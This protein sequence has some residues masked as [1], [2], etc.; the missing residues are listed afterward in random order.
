MFKHRYSEV[1]RIPSNSNGIQAL[2]GYYN[3]QRFLARALRKLGVSLPILD[4]FQDE[5]INF[6]TVAIRQSGKEGIWPIFDLS[7][8]GKEFLAGFFPGSVLSDLL[9]SAMDGSEQA[10]NRL[11]SIQAIAYAIRLIAPARVVSQVE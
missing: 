4:R 1:A 10:Y 5:P 6:D 9:N 8:E 11:V 3:Q 2:T 7:T